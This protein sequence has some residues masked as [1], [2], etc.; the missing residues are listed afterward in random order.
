MR[1]PTT[2]TIAAVGIFWQIHHMQS[3][4]ELTLSFSHCKL[5]L[6]WPNSLLTEPESVVSWILSSFYHTKR[7]SNRWMLGKSS[8]NRRSD[9]PKPVGFFRSGSYD[10]WS[11]DQEVFFENEFEIADGITLIYIKISAIPSWRDC[12]LCDPLTYGVR[13]QQDLIYIKQLPRSR[14]I[15]YP[16]RLQKTCQRTQW[17]LR[18]T[19]TENPPFH[20]LQMKKNLQNLSMF[21]FF[22][23]RSF[24]FVNHFSPST[25]WIFGKKTPNSRWFWAFTPYRHR[26]K[27]PSDSEK[28]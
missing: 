6:G 14:V 10:H 19:K 8:E 24:Q 23:F 18:R 25:F 1:R 13:L 9:N 4:V 5:K 7:F 22:N 20:E 2:T 11:C 15:C 21:K 26:L 3:P 16:P 28:R 17:N 12:D 27:N